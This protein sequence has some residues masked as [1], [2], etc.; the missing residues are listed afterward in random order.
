MNVLRWQNAKPG[1]SAVRL[2]SQSTQQCPSLS[3][4]N[5]WLK[6]RAPLDLRSRAESTDDEC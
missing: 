2:R 6:R 5:S 3:I 4:R 1:T